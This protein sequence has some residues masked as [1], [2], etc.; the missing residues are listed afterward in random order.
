[1]SK[2]LR[3]LASTHFPYTTLFRSGFFGYSHEGNIVTFPRGGSDITGSI[4]AAGVHATEY[5]NFTDVDCIYS[6]NPSIVE[7]PHPVKE[8]TYQEMR[9]LSYAGFSVFHDE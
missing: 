3:P 7:N 9:E 2:I 5:E 6:V 8:L 1:P 4:I